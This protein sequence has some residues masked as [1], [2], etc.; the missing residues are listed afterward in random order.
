[1]DPSER[2]TLV[3]SSRPEIRPLPHDA[4]RS[5]FLYNLLFPFAFV[6][7]LPG[8]LARMLRRGNFREHFGQRLGRYKAADRQRL[9]DGRWIWIHSISVGETIIALKLARA[10]HAEDP[11]LQVL[12]SVTTST[13]FALACQATESWL[14]VSYNP[15][16]AAP[17]VRRALDLI[18]P[19]RLILVEGETWPNLLAECHRRG[20]SVALVD[21][22][23][24]RRSEAR[25]GRFRRWITPIFRL[26]DVVCV[27]DAAD[28]ARWQAL[29]VAASRIH[30]TGSIKFDEPPSNASSRVEEF[31][32]LLAQLGVVAETPILLGGSTWAPEEKTLAEILR[33]VRANHPNLFLILVPRHVERTSDILRDL[34]PLGLRV[35]RRSEL[36]AISDES[37]SNSPRCDILLVDTTGELRDWYALATVVF[38]GKSLEAFG[39]QNPAE[40]AALGKPV[41]TGPHMENFAGLIQLLTSHDAVVQAPDIATLGQHLLALLSDAPRRAELGTRAREALG[42]HRGATARVASLLA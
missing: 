12:V 28:T 6:A 22:R 23:I 17:I 26:L 25:F 39:G 21:A 42:V 30:H 38:I 10:L 36:S 34:A 8:F 5:L 29:G 9:A 3:T 40:P 31:R 18:R 41:V 4:R 27:T 32:A 11:S 35:I 19:V 16:D 20:I 1:M 24:S 13:G 37:S 14:Q 7:L 15:I 33:M 2:R